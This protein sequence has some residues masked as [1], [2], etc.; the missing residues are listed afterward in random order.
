MTRI[1]FITETLTIWNG[2]LE[3][4]SLIDIHDKVRNAIEVLTYTYDSKE[5]G[6]LK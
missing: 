3:D 6:I 4:S 5:L 1:D 2:L